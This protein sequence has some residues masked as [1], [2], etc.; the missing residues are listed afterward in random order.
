[1][2]DK[3]AYP[4]SNVTVRTVA[5]VAAATGVT[6]LDGVDTT[7]APPSFVAVAVNV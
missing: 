2:R 1:M 3:P 5:V 6:E 4:E 7:E